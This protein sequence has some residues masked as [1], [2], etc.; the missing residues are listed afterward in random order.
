MSPTTYDI[1]LYFM[2][3]EACPGLIK[4][5]TR[6]WDGERSVFRF[7]DVELTLTVK[8]IRDVLDTVGMETKV[9]T[10]PDHNILIP[11]KPTTK[12]MLNMLLFIKED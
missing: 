4:V 5:I 12:E 7:G 2:E 3:I 1:Y 10:K 6:Y 9:Q 11:H 8:E